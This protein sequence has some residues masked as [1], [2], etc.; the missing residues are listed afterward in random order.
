MM[1]FTD[2][3]CHLFSE[4]FDDISDVIERAR[5]KGVEKIIVPATNLHNAHEVVNLCNIYPNVYCAVGIHPNDTAQWSGSEIDEIRL[6]AKNEK[7]IAIGEIGLDYHYDYSPRDKQITAFRDQLNL[8]IELKLPVILH[9][10]ESD[11]DMMSIVE[12]FT[13]KGL[14]AHLHCFNGSVKDALTYVKLGH[15]ISFTGNITFQKA[16]DLRAVAKVVSLE[17]LLIETDSPY[18]TP[19]P[20]RGKRNEPNNIPL[21]AEKLAEIHGV[22]VEDIARITELNTWRFYGI[23]EEPKSK[24]TYQIGQSL[25]INVSNRCNADCVFCGRKDAPYIHG[26]NLRLA[27][28]DEPSIEEYLKEIGDPKQ[29][30][31]V[32]FCGYGEPTI[33]LQ[34]I[35]ELARIIKAAGGKTRINTN[36]HGNVINKR[37]I[38]GDLAETMDLISISLNSSDAESYAQIMRV[39][40]N[41]YGE[42]LNFAKLLKTKGANVVLSI[43]SSVPTELEK[44]REIASEIGVPLRERPYF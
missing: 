22:S 5:E 36:G 32:V 10:R 31:D 4:Y 1:K 14:K 8:A 23:G 18:M 11:A 12:E 34:I 29:Y 42:M 43:V 39:S 38:T 35:I 24:I 16:D 17:H 30:K 25:Y 7:V 2:T 27:K 37:D 21:V 20:F 19:V 13:H 28:K 15:F 40:P 26:Y 9:N 3:H 44:C 6:L 33:R 41:M